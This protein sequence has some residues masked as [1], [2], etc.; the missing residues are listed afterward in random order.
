MKLALEERLLEQKLRF[1]L[2]VNGILAISVV[3]AAAYLLYK[4]L[5]V[6]FQ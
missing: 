4:I 1:Y 2:M 6:I 3:T 5:K